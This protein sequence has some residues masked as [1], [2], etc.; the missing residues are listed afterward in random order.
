[1]EMVRDV[2]TFVNKNNS[3]LKSFF[4]YKTRIL[5]KDIIEEHIQEFYYKLI[6]TNALE[7]FDEKKGSFDTYIATLLC[8]LLPYKA[9]KNVSV[10]YEFISYVKVEKAMKTNVEDI[11]DHIDKEYGPYKI[12]CSF[13][14]PSMLDESEETLISLDIQEFKEYIKKTEKGRLAEQMLTFIEKRYEGLLSAD[15]ALI[16]G[17]SDN[18]VKIIKKKVRRKFE[19]WKVLR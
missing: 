18:M 6:H 15:I 17:I 14:N 8:W 7:N 4:K 13:Y 3:Q 19:T 10:K 1:M 9:K 2:E 5:D 16:L 12:D 11:W